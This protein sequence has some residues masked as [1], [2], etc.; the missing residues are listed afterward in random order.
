M[1]ISNSRELPPSRPNQTFVSVSPI[2][3]GSITLPERFFVSPSDPDAKSTVPS[4]AFLIT[5]P[6]SQRDGSQVRLMFDLGL[7][8][9]ME[10]YMPSQQKHL[11]DGRVPYL[12]GPGVAARLA[13]AGLNSNSDVDLV[14]LSHVHYDHHGDPRDFS[15]STF[16]L[17]PGSL[18]VLEGKG[19]AKGSH[20]H[21]DSDLLSQNHTVELPPP[22]AVL[23][24]AWKPIGPFP[25]AIDLF[26][27]GSV[28]VIDSPGHLPGHLNLLCRT[29][30]SDW[31]LL[32]GDTCHDMR[33]LTGEREIGF[34]EDASGNSICIHADSVAAKESIAR[35][36]QLSELA[37]SGDSTVT[38]IMAHDLEWYNFNRQK[39]FPNSV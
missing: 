18:A 33:L 31:I 16:I 17:G 30:P 26:D 32:G 23:R 37:Q 12:L 38:V 29:G 24:S 3:G 27:D 35:V 20:Q 36:R 8:S 19:T 4:L 21:F 9:V 13:D 22:Q 25:S 1:A 5:H 15:N 11:K 6:D 10:N 28:Y 14:I 7:R 39:F 2:D 34:W